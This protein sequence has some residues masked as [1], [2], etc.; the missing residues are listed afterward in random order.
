MAGA[1][2][3]TPRVIVLLAAALAETLWMV[4]AAGVLGLA[5]GTALGVSLFVT[6]PGQ[7]EARPGAYRILST[8][9][10]TIRAVPFIILI[11]ALIPLTRFIAGTSIGTTA[12]IVPLV[13]G[14]TPFVGRI[15]ESALLEVPVSQ[16]EA[17][18]SL[19]ASSAQVVLRVMLPEALPAIAHGATLTLITLVSYSAVAGAVGGGGLGDLG[20]RYGY[21]RF[22]TGVMVAVVLT[23]VALVQ[24][25][26]TLGDRIARALDHR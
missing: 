5:F 18:R 17:A 12:A 2:R 20:I 15:V 8:L 3:K 21:Q 13:I 25:V 4:S 6:R 24:L 26:Q 23:L 9:A 10:N 22:D 7:A 14:V 16:G 1:C 11:V 19:G